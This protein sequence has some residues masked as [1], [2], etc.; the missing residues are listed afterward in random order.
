MRS[1][2]GGPLV[3]EAGRAGMAGWDVRRDRRTFGAHGGF[4]AGPVSGLVAV[5][6]IV[7]G[8]AVRAGPRHGVPGGGCGARMSAATSGRPQRDQIRA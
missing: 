4:P 6:V 7:N 1:I 8:A 3:L 5:A 2:A